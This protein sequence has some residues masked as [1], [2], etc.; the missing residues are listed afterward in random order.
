MDG[1]KI[2][3][4]LMGV[5]MKRFLPFLLLFVSLISIP[6]LADGITLFPNSGSGDN[7]A[8]VSQ[9][10]GHPLSL[11]GGTDPS[12]L[13][14]DGYPAGM[15]VG[16]GG[17]LFLYSAVIWVD[18]SPLEFFFDSASIFMTSFTLPTNGR[19]FIVP[20][21]ISFEASGFN[22]DTEQRINLSGRDSGWIGFSY[23]NGFY[24]PGDFV[25]G[26]PP[27]TV[28]EPSTLG[29]IGMGLTSIAA[30]ARKKRRPDRPR[31]HRAADAKYGALCG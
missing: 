29:L 6:A 3:V 26:P 2:G 7:F 12:F 1:C 19:D 24:Y 23:S 30:L 18:G 9:M 16:G 14:A 21:D 15:A 25:Q 28:P 27:V 13:R 17:G 8:F 11:F 22:F 10:N 4:L 20:V 5:C 31:S